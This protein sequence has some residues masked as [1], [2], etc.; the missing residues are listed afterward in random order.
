MKAADTGSF[1]AEYLRSALHYEPET[2]VFTWL[3]RRAI[4][5]PAGSFAGSIHA[6]TGYAGIKIKGRRYLAHR[7]AWLYMTGEWP[8]HQI[9]HINLKKSDNRWCNLREATHGQNI[10]NQAGY[11]ESGLKGAY[12]KGDAYR[13]RPWFSAINLGGV[14]RHLGYFSTPEE[15]NAAYAKAAADNFGHFA[16][17]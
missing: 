5:T 13:S 11:A 10:C 2:G 7:L 9:D 1:T 6:A 3:V 8:S 4:G 14:I 15:A 17:S 12:Y 16:R